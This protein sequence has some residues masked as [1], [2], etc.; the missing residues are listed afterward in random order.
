MESFSFESALGTVFF[1]VVVFVAGA[2]VGAPLW[3]WVSGFLPW[4]K[5]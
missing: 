2:L 5:K 3:K 4:N 1:T